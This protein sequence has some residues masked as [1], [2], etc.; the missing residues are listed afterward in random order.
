MAGARGIRI[1][2]G[3]AALA[4]VVGIAAAALGIENDFAAFLRAWHVAVVAWLVIPLGCLGLLLVHH[5]TGGRWGRVLRGALE[6]GTRTLPL[7]AILFVPV[8]VHLDAVF[9]WARADYLA[10]HEVVARKTGYLDEPFF[11]ARS[12]VYLAV[13]VILAVAVTVARRSSLT[14]PLRHLWLGP[15]G[16]VLLVPT[17]SFASVDWILS[18][19]PTFHSSVFGMLTLAAM[20]VAGLAFAILVTLSLAAADRTSALREQ[21]DV[22]LGRLLLALSLL[23]VYFAFMQYLIIWSGDLPHTA[24]WYLARQEGL[25]LW[26]IRTVVAVHLSVFVLLLF[27]RARRSWRLLPSLCAFLLV[28][29]FLDSAWLMLPAFGDDAPPGWLVAATM[30]AVGGLWLLATFSLATPRTRAAAH[31]VEEASHG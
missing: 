8:L 1:V 2:Q 23:W 7:L 11:I 9:P 22:G 24:E 27:S 13:W 12:A 3:A 4:A 25:W 10:E 30:L 26:I 17:V 31:A 29:R 20:A 21:D 18:L 28:V 14:P 5:L 6:A 16:A 15:L 19:A